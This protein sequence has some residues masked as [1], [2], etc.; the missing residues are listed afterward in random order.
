MIRQ[1]VRII[2][3]CCP[4]VTGNSVRMLP[5]YALNTI[6]YSCILSS[7]PVFSSLYYILNTIYYIL[8]L[9]LPSCLYLLYFLMLTTIHYSLTTVLIA[10]L[11]NCSIDPN[12]YLNL[13]WSIGQLVN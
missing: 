2:P 8:F 3:E 1:C 11:L 4:D 12:F 9:Y 10:Q 13:N 7:S 6:Y 5:E